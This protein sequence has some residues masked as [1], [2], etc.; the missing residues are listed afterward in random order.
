MDIKGFHALVFVIYLRFAI[1]I[2]GNN[3]NAVGHQRTELHKKG[4]QV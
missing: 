1:A 4:S 3:L 2:V